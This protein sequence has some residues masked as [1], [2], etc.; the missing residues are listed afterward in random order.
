MMRDMKDHHEHLF[1][2]SSKDCACGQQL[3][4]YKA[5]CTWR[6]ARFVEGDGPT[7]MGWLQYVVLVARN[8]QDERI[9]NA[10]DVA[11]VSVQPLPPLVEEGEQDVAHANDEYGTVITKAGLLVMFNE[12]GFNSTCIDVREL[13]TWLR[14]NRPELLGP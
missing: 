1:R 5:A 12:G 11:R 13:V 8:S 2:W 9:R 14:A 4:L 10:R 7:Q 3:D 6:G